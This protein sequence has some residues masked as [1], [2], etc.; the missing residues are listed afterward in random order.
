M[1]NARS[2]YIFLSSVFVV[3]VHCLVSYPSHNSLCVTFLRQSKAVMFRHHCF[4]LWAQSSPNSELSWDK[5]V[6][7]VTP[8]LALAGPVS[9]GVCRCHSFP[10]CG[11]SSVT[12]TSVFYQLNYRRT[13]MFL[14][15]QIRSDRQDQLS[16]P[17]KPTSFQRNKTNQ[18]TAAGGGKKKTKRDRGEN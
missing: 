11:E 16:L 4:S 13:E 9:A 18:W 5:S 6:L 7:S 14:E 12:T 15:R 2:Q 3:V 1:L 17:D 8:G 10:Q